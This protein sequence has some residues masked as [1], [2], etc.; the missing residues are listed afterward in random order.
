MFVI[1]AKNEHGKTFNVGVTVDEFNPPVFT[2]NSE[3]IGPWYVNSDSLLLRSLNNRLIKQQAELK[4]M[5]QHVLKEVIIKSQRIISG[6][7]NLNG[8]AGADE[9]L[10][11]KDMEKAGK[12]TLLQMLQQK[13]ISGFTEIDHVYKLHFDTLFLIIDGINVDDFFCPGLLPYSN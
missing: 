13:M 1:Q 9:V 11:E 10:D 4:L 7:K 6:S 12:M 5:G 8:A 3:T 2:E